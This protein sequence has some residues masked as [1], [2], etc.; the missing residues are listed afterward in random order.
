MYYSIARSG[1]AATRVPKMPISQGCHPRR[2]FWLYIC[3]VRCHRYLHAKFQQ[4]LPKKKTQNF[5]FENLLHSFSVTLYSLC[6]KHCTTAL[7]EKS[8]VFFTVNLFENLHASTYDYLVYIYKV[9]K[10]PRMATLS[11]SHHGN[12]GRMQNFKKID[13]QKNQTFFI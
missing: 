5:P 1:V 9:K 2:V 4:D 6:Q 3:K 10:M 7:T 12:P 8:R 13:R 11:Y